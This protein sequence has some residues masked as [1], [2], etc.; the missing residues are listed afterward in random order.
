MNEIP[1]YSVIWCDRRQVYFVRHFID[2]KKKCPFYGLDMPVNAWA[3]IC[4]AFQE[5]NTV[6]EHFERFV[7]LV[8][9]VSVQKVKH[10]VTHLQEEIW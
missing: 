6:E 3:I 4:T 9:Q 2:Y 5:F 1:K 8:T 10:K 7:Q